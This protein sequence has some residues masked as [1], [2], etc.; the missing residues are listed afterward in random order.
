MKV[1]DPLAP[2][3]AYERRLFQQLLELVTKQIGGESIAGD[4][5]S[6]HYAVMQRKIADDT[7]WAIWRARQDLQAMRRSTKRQEE[8]S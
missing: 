6:P 7:A 2:R 4:R 5:A 3:G 1:G 8:G